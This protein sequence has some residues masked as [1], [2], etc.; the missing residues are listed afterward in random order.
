MSKA[1]HV[2]LSEP[3]RFER[4]THVDQIPD[5]DDWHEYPLTRVKRDGDGW[6]ISF[7]S[8]W[9]S[10]LP[11]DKNLRGIEP[12]VGDVYRFY[13]AI[14]GPNRGRAVAGQV[15]WYETA[16]EHQD[17]TLREQ[18]KS[19]QLKRE[20]FYAEEHADFVKRRDA[21]PDVFRERIAVR[22]RNNPDFDW[23]YGQ[24]E[25]FCCEQAVLIANTLGSLEAVEA[26]QQAEWEQQLARVPGLSDGH[27]GNTFGCAC[28]LAGWYLKNP[29]QVPLLHGAMSPL[30]GSRAYG[31]IAEDVPA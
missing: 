20:A 9:E 30:V 4:Y 29:S 12:R 24:Y 6:E 2:D 22:E 17:R 28:A 23:E 19:N 11:D 26:F 3:F 31:D 16:E 25:L 27:S 7:G 14:W 5:D 10:Y 21:L 18:A 1:I 8:C 13:G 15:L